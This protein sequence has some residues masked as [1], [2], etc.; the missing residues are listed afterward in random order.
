MIHLEVDYKPNDQLTGDERKE[1]ELRYR[2]LYGNRMREGSRHYRKER[3][4]PVP[5][6]PSAEEQVQNAEAYQQ[7]YGRFFESLHRGELPGG[8][9]REFPEG[10]RTL[11]ESVSDYFDTYWPDQVEWEVTEETNDGEK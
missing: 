10:A 3:G 7:T 9:N 11:E 5:A 8:N 1:R 2:E 6:P 4:E